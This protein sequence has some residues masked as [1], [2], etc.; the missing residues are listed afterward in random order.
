MHPEGPESVPPPLLA[1]GGTTVEW[2]EA[3]WFC[4]DPCGSMVKVVDRHA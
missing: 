4:Q 3:S 1:G 2:P